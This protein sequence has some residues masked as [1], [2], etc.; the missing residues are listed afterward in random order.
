[1]YL[2]FLGSFFSFVISIFLMYGSFFSFVE[3]INIPLIYQGDGLSVSWLVKR[4]I[5]GW[6]FENERSGFPFGS[7][8]YDYP[9]SDTFIFIIQSFFGRVFKSNS[10]AI[11][12]YIFFSFIAN[13]ASAFVVMRLMKISKLVSFM[14]AVLFNFLPFHFQRF[15]H[16][17]Y[18]LYFNIPIYFYYAYKIY[19][20]DITEDFSFKSWMKKN[21][22]AIPIL[23][24]CA[25]TGVYY[26]A[27][28]VIVL[29]AAILGSCFK[30]SSLK[31]ILKGG[32]YAAIIVGTVFLNILPS[33]FYNL[34]HGK[35][36]EVAQRSP[37]ESE[38]YGLKLT[39]LV[40]PRADHRIE[41]LGK[42]TQQYNAHAP[43]V[44]ENATST[45]GVVGTLGFFTILLSILS[46]G[47]RFLI[48]DPRL[49]FFSI[50]TFFMFIFA[51]VGG[52]S[53]LF[54]S[55]ISPL[56]RAWN[57]ISPFIAFSSLTFLGVLFDVYIKQKISKIKY[58]IFILG[59]TSVGLYD[60]TVPI[61]KECLDQAKYI[62]ETDKK[63][64]EKIESL[65][66][67]GSS[68]FQYP[69]IPFPEWH[70]VHHLETYS[71]AIGF[72]H[73]KELKWNY[74][75]MKGRE[76]DFFYRALDQEALNVQV[77]IIKKLG[78]H[79]LYI[80]R[81]GY[82]DNGE[83]FISQLTQLLGYGPE[84]TSEDGKITFFKLKDV[85]MQNFER[86]KPKEIM[87]KVGFY[88]D[89]HGARYNH[90]L[91][92]GIDFTKRGLPIFI[93][94]VKGL[95]G[96]EPWGR[97]SEGSLTTFEF[98]DALLSHFKLKL[99]AT[100]FGDN[101]GQKMEIKIG[102]QSYFMDIDN[103]SFEKEIVVD[104]KDKI[105]DKIDFIIPRPQK[106]ENGD[107]REIGIGFIHL[108]IEEQ[109]T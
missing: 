53:M 91:S 57:R 87:K 1:M 74:A 65:L 70:H 9:S 69:Y 5:E 11:N 36:V 59:V 94:D 10:L 38:I 37:G 108:K 97:W 50:T 82:E 7:S 46:L 44:N 42:L 99:K 102:K 60:Q 71:L 106:P 105:T 83:A 3:N 16:L 2:V 76:G 22:W 75:G 89:R 84:F 81:R 48:F 41:K 47:T 72:I 64:I 20:E 98:Q 15:G 101:V 61:N 30:N 43:L 49:S 54:S 103:T 55:L 95:S 33:I 39:Q 88:V 78:F 85:E 29:T 32:F 26:T 58:L 68:V 96:Y 107:Q 35:N 62:F 6:I 66:P 93:K 92:E 17:F 23:M 104:L 100:A 24:I 8:F 4:T 40:I 31:P 12:A 80:D 28:G 21:L 56:I 109:N 73:S 67:K 27:F 79:G 51:T 34:E 14:G 90:T 86:L 13:F 63:T 77:E 45:L 25:S 52:L 18:V 19:K